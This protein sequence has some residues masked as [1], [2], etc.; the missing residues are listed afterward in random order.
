MEFGYRVCGVLVANYQ[1]EYAEAPCSHQPSLLQI[2]QSKHRFQIFVSKLIP[3]RPSQETGRL[4]HILDL[5]TVQL[6]LGHMV[7]LLIREGLNVR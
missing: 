5:A 6:G 3:L 4:D 1:Y 2:S 7:K